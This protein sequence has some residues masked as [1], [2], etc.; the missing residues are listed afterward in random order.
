[1]KTY[2]STTSERQL[3][4][5]Q[6]LTAGRHIQKSQLAK[7]FT[8]DARTIQRDFANLRA[9]IDEYLPEYT[10]NYDRQ[11]NSYWLFA[12]GI[13]LNKAQCL[14]LIKILT[15]SRAL[16][17]DQLI[18]LSNRLLKI[19]D[20]K[21]A[22]K[23]K[24]LIS[25]E[26]STYQPLRNLQNK[27]LMNLIW[28][29]SEY[30]LLHR[31]IRIDYRNQAG[32]IKAHTIIPLALTFSDNYFYLIG[33]TNTYKKNIIYRLDRIIDYH[34]SQK[35]I[36]QSEWQAHQWNEGLT[37]K[38]LQLMYPGKNV[39]ILF[40]YR[41]VV[42]AAL[43]KFPLS[44]IVQ[45]KTD[46]QPAIIEVETYDTGAMMW[47]LSQKDMVT[48]LEPEWFQEQMITTLQKMLSNYQ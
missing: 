24:Q 48:V 47:L 41:G 15:A 28:N 1:M 43:D 32:H 35:S 25:S 44:K 37:K 14:C 16:P 38:K 21:D 46:Q 11:N 31:T 19:L 29:F 26:Q 12:N 23:V 22:Q 39:K 27:D 6:Q 34:I 9:F 17:K 3:F 8:V 30:T 36:P 18:E 42:E 2:K 20:E 33:Y 5:Y 7:Q 10:L 45:P 40:E 4:I 13:G